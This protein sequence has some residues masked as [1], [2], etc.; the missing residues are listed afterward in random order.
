[1]HSQLVNSVRLSAV[2]NLRDSE[3]LTGDRLE[4]GETTDRKQ[5][6]LIIWF[7][8]LFQGWTEILHLLLCLQSKDVDSE[9]LIMQQ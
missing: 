3:A 1:M 6:N 5:K 4:W 7:L 9:T 8:L 2:R